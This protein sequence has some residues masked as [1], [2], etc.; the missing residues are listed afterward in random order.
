MTCRIG[1]SAMHMACSIKILPCRSIEI[2]YNVSNIDHL[3]FL[4]NLL[5]FN[6]AYM[7]EFLSIEFESKRLF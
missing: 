3:F 4:H 6:I 5:F 7:I 1:L 2:K